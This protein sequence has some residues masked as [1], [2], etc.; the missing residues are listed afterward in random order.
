[1]TLSKKLAKAS[2][3]PVLLI[4]SATPAHALQT[5]EARDGVAVEA[6]MSIKEP[7]RIRIDGAPITHVFGNIY[8]SSCGAA[9]PTAT[10][11][12]GGTPG[13]P[14]VTTPA[15]NAAGEVVI[16]CDPD[17]GEIYIRPVPAIDKKPVNLF[18]SSAHGTYTLLLRPA[19]TPADTILIRDRSVRAAA[20]DSGHARAIDGTGA[21]G[22][23]RHIRSLKAMLLGMTAP[24]PPG[25]LQVQSFDRTVDLWREARFTL[26][27]VYTG[28]G[29]VGE[30]YE[31]QNVSNDDMVLAEQEFDRESGGV[32]GVAIE[33][34]NLRPGDATHVYVLRRG[35]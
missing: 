22:A 34:H 4:G 29:L 1:M 15:V 30:I 23:S 17:K 10:A 11:P 7:T 16:E 33:H 27:Q 24:Q 9:A 26:R 32:L 20:A 28:R 35:D 5:L 12:H 21:E 13:V 6:I 8:S 18:V 2:L 19:D 25:D 3:L 31:L 14:A